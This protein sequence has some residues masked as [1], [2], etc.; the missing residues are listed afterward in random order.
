M[1]SGERLV[2]GRLKIRHL[3]LVT[4][5]LDAGGVAAAANHLRVTQPVVTRGLKE[6]EDVLGTQLF[7]R[8]PRGVTPTPA[9]LA[10]AQHARSVLAEIRASADH[11]NWLEEGSAGVVRVGTHTAGANLL[12][13]QA[14]A[15][16]KRGR[17]R[18]L[19]SVH[20]AT[21]DRL[22]NL[23]IAGEVDLTVGR[24][25][26]QPASGTRSIRLHPEPIVIAVRAGH[27]L[28][29]KRVP[30]GD[31]LA[32]PWIFPGA[33]TGLRREL[34]ESFSKL[35]LGLPA[36]LIESSSI[37]TTRGLLL[38][39]DLVAAVPA[40]HVYPDDALSTIDVDVPGIRRVVGA[41]LREGRSTP[42]AVTLMIESLKAAAGQ[43]VARYPQVGLL[44]E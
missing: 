29:G 10:F 41:S 35:G 17:P 16:L 28:A 34:D 19:V 27:P 40:L 33:T 6:I 32:S 21:P 13:P 2:D 9:G 3:V 44:D 12:L 7:D 24:L 22:T 20:E 1:I 43:I 8:G 31:L 23:L 11:L 4:T 26:A 15:L 38:E 30:I 36:D 18:L 37:A 39:S 42:P 14:I 25:P 5:I